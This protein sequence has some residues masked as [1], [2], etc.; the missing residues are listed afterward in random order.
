MKIALQE[1]LLPGDE[2]AEKLDFAEEL[3]GPLGKIDVPPGNW[4][5]GARIDG[6]STHKGVRFPDCPYPGGILPI[7][8][9]VIHN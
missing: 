8:A 7:T 3:A 4:V 5:K 6:F 1:G 2:L 9:R